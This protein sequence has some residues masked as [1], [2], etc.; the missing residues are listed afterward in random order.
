MCYYVYVIYSKSKDAY[1]VGSTGDLGRRLNEHNTQLN[2]EAFS[3]IA[4]DWEYFHTIECSN[5]ETARKIERDIKKMKSRIYNENLAKYKEIS[6]K[7][8]KKI[9]IADG[10]YTDSYR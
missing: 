4:T 1:Y 10:R 5:I 9:H 8:L 6:D 7:L 3:K 2:Q